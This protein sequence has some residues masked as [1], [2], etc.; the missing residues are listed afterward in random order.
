LSFNKVI[1]SS[2]HLT[3][4][5]DRSIPR[6]P[7]EK[8]ALVQSSMAKQLEEWKVGAGDLA[9][10]GGARGSDL[11]FAELCLHRGA[12]VWLFISLDEEA[13][14]QESVRVPGTDWEQRYYSLRNQKNVKTYW[15]NE[16]DASLKKDSSPFA[17]ANSWMIDECIKKTPSSDKLYALLVWDQQPVGDGPGGTADFA[18]RIREAGGQVAIINPLMV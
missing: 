17:A 18:A 4:K 8:A 7:E 2:G 3:D 10:C 6:F 9:V 13:F 16:Q 1:V 11:L 5:P 15:L 12:T 14:L